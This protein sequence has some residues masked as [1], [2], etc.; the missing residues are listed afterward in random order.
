MTSDG[1]R[2]VAALV[3][4]LTPLGPAAEGT[5]YRLK[6]TGDNLI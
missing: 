5:C 3:A 4:A 2:A 6:G 1:S